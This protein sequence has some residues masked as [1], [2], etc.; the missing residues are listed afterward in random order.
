MKNA[1]GNFIDSILGDLFEAGQFETV[2]K[3]WR[4]VEELMA[5]FVE[6]VVQDISA[7]RRRNW[8]APDANLC[9]DKPLCI[10]IRFT[11]PIIE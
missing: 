3:S 8:N 6:L 1:I 5:P 9:I 11:I 4:I 10:G 2:P 7:R